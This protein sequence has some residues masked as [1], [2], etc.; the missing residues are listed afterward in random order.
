MLKTLKKTNSNEKYK[1]LS[2]FYLKQ[3][4]NKGDNLSDDRT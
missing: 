1:T 3:E 4:I 2:I